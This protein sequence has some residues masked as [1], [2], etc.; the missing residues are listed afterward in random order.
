MPHVISIPPTY[1]MQQLQYMNL[2]PTQPFGRSSDE[3]LL[4]RFLIVDFSKQN[5]PVLFFRHIYQA[6][7]ISTRL[8]YFLDAY[9]R[10]SELE[11]ACSIFQDTYT[12]SLELVHACSIFQDTYT[13]YSELVHA[14]SIFQDTYTRYS[15]LE[16]VCSIFLDT[17][18]RFL[19]I[20]SGS[21]QRNNF[22]HSASL[23]IKIQRRKGAPAKKRLRALPYAKLYNGILCQLVN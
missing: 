4:D 13:R 10:Y 14:C 3:Y 11:H 20:I 21:A 18:T 8:F 12:R 15:E 1:K 5:R 23:V 6:P 17:Y 2:L 9:T 19:E 7:G 22:P 16:Y